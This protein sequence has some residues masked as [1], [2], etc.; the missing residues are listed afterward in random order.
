MYVRREHSASD[1]AMVFYFG[2]ASANLLLPLPRGQWQV[3]LD[4][5]DS[6]WLGPGGI[7]GVLES[8]DEVSVSRDGP[9]VLLLVRQ[10]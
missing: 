8:E 9:S 10:E 4:S 3:A 2:D 6:V 1:A 5:S 7:H